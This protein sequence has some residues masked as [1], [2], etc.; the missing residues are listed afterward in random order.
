MKFTLDGGDNEDNLQNVN[1]PFPFPDAVEEFSV[2]TSNAAAETGKSSAGA[3]NVVTKSGTNAFHGN[4]FWFLRNTDLNAS[5][6]FLHQSDDL[7]RNQAGGTVG[8]PGG[9]N[10]LF[11][12]GGFQQTWIRTQPHREQDAHHAGRLP[13]RQLLGAAEAGQAGGDHRPYDQRALR[14]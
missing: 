2:Q 11:F 12:F 3:V 14:R 1:M 8:R 5:S 9:Q 4:G 10:K 6:Y 7:K 13:D